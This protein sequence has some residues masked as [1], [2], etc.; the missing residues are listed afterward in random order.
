MEAS[1]GVVFASTL[2]VLNSI[3]DDVKADK[4]LNDMFGGKVLEN[5]VLVVKTD[6]FGLFALETAGISK[7]QE[8]DFIAQAK[9]ILNKNIEMK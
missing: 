7:E 4:K 8:D 3:I 5:T 1:K 2:Q 9:E 6:A